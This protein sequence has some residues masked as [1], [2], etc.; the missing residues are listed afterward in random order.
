MIET[1]L[2]VSTIGEAFRNNIINKVNDTTF[3]MTEAHNDT[4]LPAIQDSIEAAIDDILLSINGFSIT[5]PHGIQNVSAVFG[6]EVVRIGTRNY[7]ISLLV[8]NGL[9][10]IAICVV[11]LYTGLFRESPSFDF[12]DLGAMIAGVRNGAAGS[13]SRGDDDSDLISWKGDPADPIVGQSILE[14]DCQLGSTEA[15]RVTIR[16]ARYTPF[17]SPTW[18]LT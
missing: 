4:I 13:R 18:N 15:S 12:T 5:R 17:P 3:N 2:Y 8:L 9:A 1:T 6:I 14:L 11:T 7:I 16:P 10:F